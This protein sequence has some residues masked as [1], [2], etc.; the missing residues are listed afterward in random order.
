MMQRNFTTYFANI[1]PVISALVICLTVGCREISN[2]AIQ[3]DHK[4]TE[5]MAKSYWNLKRFETHNSSA[6]F[7]MSD[8]EIIAP[9]PLHERQNLPPATKITAKD[10]ARC[11]EAIR[12]HPDAEKSYFELGYVYGEL[13]LY[14]KA[15]DNYLL[16]IHYK[17]QYIDA[18]YNLGSAYANI[19]QYDKAIKAYKKVIVIDPT[20]DVYRSLG[21]AYTRLDET[22][23][24]IK[25]CNQEINSDPE[26]FNA[27]FR[28]GLIYKEIDSH[29]N[30]TLQFLEVIKR[31]PEHGDAFFYLAN[32]YR[33]GK[34]YQKAVEAYLL[35][36]S[37][38]ANLPMSH[39][40]LGITYL[41]MNDTNGAMKQYK[42]LK[43]LDNKLAIKL[44]NQINL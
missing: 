31:N 23:Q 3:T 40:E 24:A 17:P 21:M 37:F 7:L 15:I 9:L 27:Y 35:D 14:R 30:A 16:A 42:T 20:D 19:G 6:N 29:D 36:I 38:S 26:N 18:L 1:I 4:T 34:H 44:F 39:Y 8:P 33:H 13:R 12:L 22:K 28:L 11:K 41:D 5:Q 32:S 25:F 43:N 10:V 2:N